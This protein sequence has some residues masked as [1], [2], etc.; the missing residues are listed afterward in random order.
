MMAAYQPQPGG[1]HPGMAPHGHPGQP[2]NPAQLQQMGHPGVSGPQAPHVTQAGAMMGMQPG[3]N[4]MGAPGGMGGQHPGGMQAG[5]SGQSMAGGAPNVHAMNH[6]TPQMQ[7]QMMAQQMQANPHMAMQQHQ[8]ML[9][10]QQMQQM[11]ASNMGGVQQGGMQG[12]SPQQMQQLQQNNQGVHP[13]SVQLP[14]HL[15]QQQMQLMQQQRQQQN[16]MQQNQQMQ[17]QLAMQHANSQQS[18]QGGQQGAPNQQGSQVQHPGQMRPQSRMANPNEQN[19]GQAQQTPQPQQQQPNQQQGQPQNA[20][21]QGQQQMTPQQM[22]A[23]RQKQIQQM[24]MQQSQQM[25]PQV[26]AAMQ[27]QMSQMNQQMNQQMQPVNQGLAATQ[28]AGQFILRLML[29]CGQL[30]NFSSENGKDVAKWHE[31]IDQHFAPDGRLLHCFDFAGSQAKTFEVLRPTIARYF[32]MYFDSGAQAIRLH[33]EHPQEKNSAGNR[34]YVAFSSATFTVVYPNGARLEMTGSVNVLFGPGTDAVEC[35]ELQ[36]SHSEEIIAKSKIEELLSGWSPTMSN[37][38]NSS[39]PKMTKKQTPKAQQKLLSSL[40]GLTI[41]HFPKVSKGNLGVSKRVQQFLE[42]GETMNVMSDLISFAQ[43]K[44][45]QPEKAME[46]LVAQYEREGGPQQQQQ[47]GNPQIN[48]PAANGVPPGNR[49]PSMQH[50]QMPTPQ[51]PQN[52]HSSPAMSNLNAPMPMQNGSPHIAN[53]PGLG[54]PNM[55]PN[56]SH[57]PSPH[58]SNM[59]APQMLLQHSQQGT[60]SSAASANTSPQVNNKRRRSTVKMEAGDDGGGEGGGGGGGANKVKPSPRMG[61]KSRPG[62]AG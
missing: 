32:Q 15:M 35:M 2:M 62:G 10:R 9:R 5:M 46:A 60:N 7:Q 55:Q 41:D 53:H 12:M 44:R 17:Q 33:I 48:L 8:A 23:F 16:Q 50:M 28:V 54:P 37:K 27:Q 25:S 14:Q 61:K 1:M 38:T 59:A 51:H 34:H 31:V 22:Q 3:A 56:N 40:D 42:I 29:F 20:Q 30:S 26:R 11:Q 13:Q 21:Q 43:E 45:T 47:Q 19:Q 24:Q 6:M 18:N 39:S 57:T 49:T 36:T 4:G 58:Q 52:F